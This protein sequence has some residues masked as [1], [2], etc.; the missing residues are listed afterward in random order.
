[1]KKM[2]KQKNYLTHS[3]GP[4]GNPKQLFQPKHKKIFI[5]I[6]VPPESPS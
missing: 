2:K 4:Q 1:M 6:P 5:K 3:N